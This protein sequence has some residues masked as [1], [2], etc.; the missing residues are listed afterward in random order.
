[1]GERIEEY[2]IRTSGRL[3]TLMSSKLYQDEMKAIEEMVANAYD[4]D[5]TKV[6]IEI[7]RREKYISVEDNGIGMD[8]EG[9]QHFFDL[10]SDNKERQPYT[11]NGRRKIGAFGV[12]KI[13]VNKIANSATIYTVK[14]GF[15]RELKIDFEKMSSYK[16]LQ[17]YSFKVTVEPVQNV[18]EDFF[19]FPAFEDQKPKK[20]H[21]TFIA[22]EQ[23]KKNILPDNVVKSLRNH[24]PLRP[25]FQIFV[26][27]E[28]IT[29]SRIE[30][31]E[32]IFQI[33]EDVPGIGR[34][35]GSLIYASSS[36]G[37]R[38]GV[39]V[40]VNGRIVNNDSAWLDIYNI[41]AALTSRL[42]GDINADGLNDIITFAREG[43]DTSSEKW[44]KFKQF[45]RDKIKNDVLEYWSEQ[46]RIKELQQFDEAADRAADDIKEIIKDEKIN[47]T[48]ETTAKGIG[49]NG[50]KEKNLFIK[51]IEGMSDEEINS[52]IIDISRNERKQKIKRHEKKDEK[53]DLSIP[54]G[55]IQPTGTTD[56]PKDNIILI[57][58]VKFKLKAWLGGKEGDECEIIP[59]KKLIL[60]NAEHPHFILCSMESFDSVRTNIRRAVLLELARRKVLYEDGGDYQGVYDYYQTL[61]RKTERLLIPENTGLDLDKK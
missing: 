12:G 54:E 55:Q 21:G 29:E 60:V 47:L 33:D 41:K 7:N 53:Q 17:D 50:N 52:K 58:K 39:W 9:L 46:Q 48:S 22:L 45:I 24:M 11:K 4:A 16:H 15:C 25:D 8:K 10:G 18:D 35:H 3:I 28:Q 20:A 49:I 14:D 56:G 61:L 5:A 40:R 59:Q 26:N 38:A 13:A 30:N 27:A 57:N 19:K 36:I 23:L 42:Y 32:K 37:D 51:K 43:F 1:M 44:N 34:V 31:P 6:F 2:S